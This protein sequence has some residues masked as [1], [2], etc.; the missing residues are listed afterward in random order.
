[1]REQRPYGKHE[2]YIEGDLV[3]AVNH[4]VI[5]LEEIRLFTEVAAEMLD[6]HGYLLFLGDNTDADKF[7]PD[8]RRYIAQWSVG[9]TILGIALYKANFVARTIFSLM[10]KAINIIRKQPLPFDFFKTEEEAREWLAMLRK[11]HL[12]NTKR[13]G[14][15]GS[16]SG[17]A[18]PH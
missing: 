9:K 18:P 14:L 17:S 12:A 10:L 1:M 5:T 2:L 4:G 7:E 15:G 11:Q 6:R 8:A 13:D 16:H 3:I